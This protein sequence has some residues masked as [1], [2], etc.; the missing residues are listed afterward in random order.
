MN[1]Q[2]LSPL[3]DSSILI[4]FGNEIDLATNLR[5]HAL[6]TR[7]RSHPLA[8]VVA[9][10]P[11]YGT[12]LVHYAPLVISYAEVAEWLEAEMALVEEAAAREPRHVEVPVRYGGG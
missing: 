4:H 3:G 12:L 1:K 11:A 2:T 6:D 8:G 7:L 5:V 9:T 10:V